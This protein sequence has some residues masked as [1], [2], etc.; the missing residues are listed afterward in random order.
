MIQNMIEVE[1]R[2]GLSKDQ[3]DSLSIFLSENGKL[4]E[5]QD[6][7][8]V[9]LLDTPGY[10]MDPT[11]R[12]VDIRIRKTNGI[13]EIMVKR[14]LVEGNHARSE[15]SYNLGEMSI[16]DAQMMVRAFGISRGQWMHRR[17]SVYLYNKCEWSLVEAVPGIYYFEIE[18]EVDQSADIHR[19]KDELES[20]VKKLG[21][22]T[23][24]NKEYKDFI[25][26]LGEKV[27]K[28]VSW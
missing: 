13:N 5:I 24:S 4:K 15:T 2:G 3:F 16:E 20:E 17:K 18:K 1:V 23:F 26:F 7:E 25:F 8:M 6:R 14:K 28:W 9:L 10:D 12:E 27:N 22:K 19:V 21:Y 11:K